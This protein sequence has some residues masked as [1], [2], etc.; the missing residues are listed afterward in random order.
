MSLL[1]R[2][3]TP[4]MLEAN[5]RNARRST[6]PRSPQ[7]KAKARLNAIKHGCDS[8]VLD[9]YFRLYLEMYVTGPWEPPPRYDPKEMPIPILTRHEYSKF[10]Q[11]E[12]REFISSVARYVRPRCRLEG[13]GAIWREPREANRGARGRK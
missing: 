12:V 7:G 6:G 5:R 11:K 10:R 3:V 8:R 13:T 9:D 4:R 2:T 1:H